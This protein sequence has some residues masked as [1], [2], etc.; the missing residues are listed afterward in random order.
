MEPLRE[1]MSLTEAAEYLGI[2]PDTLYK[3]VGGATIPA[4]KLGSQ[5]RF[6]RTMLDQWMEE[7]VQRQ[8]TSRSTINE[9]VK[10]R[11]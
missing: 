1:V 10:S 2:S 11:R 4:F 8:M 6:K 7:K 9:F 5:W 3:Y